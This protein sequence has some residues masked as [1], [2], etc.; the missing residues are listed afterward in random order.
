MPTLSLTSESTEVAK[1][2]ERSRGTKAGHAAVCLDQFAFCYWSSDP[3]RALHP[4]IILIIVMPLGEM[5]GLNLK[6][7]RNDLINLIP[8]VPSLSV[9]RH[10]R[11]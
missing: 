3:R 1:L 9:N 2:P 8:G 6:I 10:S 4:R 11:L 5:L 7:L